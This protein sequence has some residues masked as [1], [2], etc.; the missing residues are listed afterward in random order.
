MLEHGTQ[1][2]TT[3]QM[4]LR[5]FV[6][7]AI[8]R[9]LRN[10][11][12]VPE[13]IVIH[14]VDAPAFSAGYT[15]IFI[16]WTD[17][18]GTWL[19]NIG[20]YFLHFT[21]NN[22]KDSSVIRKNRIDKPR[23]YKQGVLVHNE[24][25]Q[26]SLFDY[27]FKD[28]RLDESRNADSYAC[29]SKAASLL[30]ISGELVARKTLNAVF[31]GVSCTEVTRFYSCNLGASVEDRHAADWLNAFHHLYG[32]TA[33]IYNTSG[34]D[35]HLSKRGFKPVLLTN[36]EWYQFLT[37]CHIPNAETIL[38]NEELTIPN[39]SEPTPA[40]V[41]MLKRVWN[42]LSALGLLNCASLPRLKQYFLLMDADSKQEFGQYKNGTVYVHNTLDGQ[43]LYKV[44]LEEITHHITR[45]GDLSRAIQD[46]LFTAITKLMF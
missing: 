12:R 23:Y 18:I 8:D 30:A 26:S 37:N 22:W 17:E 6:A 9:T 39:A 38:S 13:D 7:N 35:G 14:K 43:I 25:G 20:H 32:S 41:A 21:S 42:D 1:D 27:N 36:K 11:D 31:S 15:R 34:I 40:Q 3:I 45:A 28:I 5:E 33:A 46:Y 4:A 29:L 2:W 19:N 24:G 16:P 10:G 44:I